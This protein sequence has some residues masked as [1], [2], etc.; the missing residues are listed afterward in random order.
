MS[1]ADYIVAFERA[2]AK[3]VRYVQHP[4][5][6]GLSSGYDSGA[7]HLAL[8]RSEFPHHSYTIYATENLDIVRERVNHGRKPL[9]N[10]NII[11]LS[12]KVVE[13]E[14]FFL[15]TTCEDYPYIAKHSYGGGVRT[16]PASAGLSQIFRQVRSLKYLV[17]LSG[18]GADEI[19][20]DYGFNG[21][22]FFMHSNF[23]GLFP[24]DLRDIFP[25]PS[26][27]LS[28]Q[29]D[30]LMKE[31]L[32]SG[33][34]GVE[35]RYPFL[36]PEVV[37]EYLWLTADI[38]NSNYKAPLHDFFVIEKYPYIPNEKVGF[39]AYDNINYDSDGTVVLKVETRERK[40]P[41]SVAQCANADNLTARLQRQERELEEKWRVLRETQQ[42]NDQN[43]AANWQQLESHVQSSEQKLAELRKM[44]KVLTEDWAVFEKYTNKR[45]AEQDH[46]NQV[47]KNG[48]DTISYN[49]IFTFVNLYEHA[50]QPIK[51]PQPHTEDV[52]VITCVSGGLALMTI[53]L[54]VYR[55]FRRTAQHMGVR[56]HNPCEDEE[57]TGTNL[58]L[59]KYVE[60]L[61]PFLDN[62]ET[63]YFVTDGADVFFNDMSS[64]LE[65]GEEFSALVRRRFAQ[66]GKRI[67]VSAERIC[68]WGGAYLCSHEEADRYPDSPTSA[69]F[70]NAGGYLG[71]AKDLH[72]MISEVIEQRAMHCGPNPDSRYCGG[73]GG[74]AD[75]Y[76][77]MQYF[78]N[79]MDIVALDYHHSIFGNFLEVG[80]FTCENQWKPRCAFT[81]CCTESDAI[82]TF[83]LT[84]NA[85]YKTRECAVWRQ[86]N[87]PVLWHG[88]GAG[89]WFYLISLNRLISHC[90]HVAQEALEQFDEDNMLYIILGMEKFQHRRWADQQDD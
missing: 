26:F 10:G 28:T 89:K 74:E 66:L 23:G 13:K 86:D 9:T 41:D 29:R 80:R 78:W 90:Q 49:M 63:L 8:Q 47:I 73:P 21:T 50:R 87:L 79:H 24:K 3:R 76:F 45:H 36:D 16:D 67:V 59:A 48:L 81:P 38:K 5:F 52:V 22:K 2:V 60:T 44:E 19:L 14:S 20:S 70:L 53:D 75:Q 54:P 40:E 83:N 57:W 69:K 35:G 46:A 88:N 15:E 27:Y 72:S 4:V 33:A 56:V 32:V 62:S 43:M 18:A 64:V 68:G 51:T 71:R 85:R 55:I 25:W 34:H 84:Y 42:S 31:E 58:R 65:R 37:Q 11:I 1:T 7:I 61:A 39:N 82:T 77:F 17:Y 30:Y 12:Q 6:I